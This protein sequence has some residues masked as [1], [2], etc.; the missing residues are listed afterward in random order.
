MWQLFFDTMKSHKGPRDAQ[1][2]QLMLRLTTSETT[3]V[4]TT[5]KDRQIWRQ[6]EKM[7]TSQYAFSIF[8]KQDQQ[9]V[10]LHTYLVSQNICSLCQPSP[11]QA[12][13]LCQGR[14][15]KLLSLGL[16]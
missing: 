9:F 4:K 2:S 5:P 13:T 16:F 14:K 8:D 11:R 10:S 7:R 6:K 12:G 3:K 1:G 15:G